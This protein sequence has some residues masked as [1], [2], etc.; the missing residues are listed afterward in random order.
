MLQY[1]NF[2]LVE[3]VNKNSINAVKLLFGSASTWH[4]DVDV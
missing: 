3:N 4:F 1:K 2:F